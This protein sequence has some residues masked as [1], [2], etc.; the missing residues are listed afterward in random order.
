MSIIAVCQAIGQGADLILKGL[1]ILF[2]D[3][4]DYI[5]NGATGLI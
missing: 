5:A 1:P 3:A 4:F 2:R